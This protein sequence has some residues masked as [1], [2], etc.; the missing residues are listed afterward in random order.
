MQR[1]PAERRD[2]QAEERDRGNGLHH[3]EDR[4]RGR[5]QR[6]D[7]PGEEGEGHAQRDGDAHGAE[8]EREMAHGLLGEDLVP[9]GVFP[10]HRQPVEEAGRKKRE[11][12]PRN[13]AK[14]H[15]PN[16]RAGRNRVSASVARREKAASAVQKP[17]AGETRA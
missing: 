6:L 1:D 16:R 10:H 11:D 17:E 15:K 4:E 2:Q 3:V 14:K 8:G 9:G 7:A 5:A 12:R 13:R